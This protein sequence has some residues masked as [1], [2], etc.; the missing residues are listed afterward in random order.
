MVCQYNFAMA[1]GELR[2]AFK[3]IG[4]SFR[5]WWDDWSNGVLVSLVT[6][7]AS[8][9]GLLAGPAILGM[10]AVADDLADGI[11]TGIAGWWGGF[12]R[13]F[14]VGLLWG[15]V[16]IIVFALAGIALW[17]YTQWD[18]P[19]SPILAIFLIVMTVIWTYVQLL[20]PG[21]LIAQ[22]DKKLGLAWKNSLFTLLA[23]PGFCL[24]SCGI[25]FVILILSLATILPLVIGT[26]PL[27]ALVSVLTVR[28]RLASY[29]KNEG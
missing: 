6:I 16:N 14:W 11:R 19:W 9:T 13:F 3:T 28:D 8:L 4:Q 17:F 18:T 10:S 25:S 2:S 15:V 23:S 1:S 29:G 12:K 24:V 7:L 21:Y 26:G 20:V 5:L 22:E 27:L